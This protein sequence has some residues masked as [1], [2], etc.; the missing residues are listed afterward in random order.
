MNQTMERHNERY[1]REF[2]NKLH[3]DDYRDNY[4]RDYNYTH[5]DRDNEDFDNY[6][7]RYDNAR[8]NYYGMRDEDATYRNVRVS[9]SDENY[10]YRSGG[11]VAGYGASSYR[12]ALNSSDRDRDSD[13][14]RYGDQN[15]YMGGDRNRD[16]GRDSH[17]DRHDNYGTSDSDRYTNYSSGNRYSRQDNSYRS[18]GS[19]RRYEDYGR[20]ER[21]TM[22]QPV[23][24]GYNMGGV[25][26][27]YDRGEQPRKR[28]E[29]N[30]SRDD[31]SNRD[32]FTN[33]SYEG[34]FDRD[35]Y[36]SRGEIRSTDRDR[37]DNYG[38]GLYASNRAYRADHDE[39]YSQ[40][41]SRYRR[42]GE[43]S[44]PD[45]G[46]NSRIGSKGYNDFGI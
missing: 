1:H 23:N 24:Q 28:W 39:D 13:H 34:G 35:N 32:R 43:T 4:R 36:S 44:G 17:S 33:N 37:D 15:R 31:R 6:R 8:G 5:R 3:H 19:G 30:Y 45:Y 11:P 42:P 21:T 18:G 26:S 29:N 46:Y 12:G 9:D 14:Y 20:D 7:D 25:D 22:D 27:Y 41:S 38:T 40:R 10:G 16:Y 2:E